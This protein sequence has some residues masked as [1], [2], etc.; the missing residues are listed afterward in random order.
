MPSTPMAYSVWTKLIKLVLN[1]KETSKRSGVRGLFED[2]HDEE[3][4]GRYLLRR[5]WERCE[6]ARK[7]TILVALAQSILTLM[8]IMRKSCVYHKPAGVIVTKVM[9][10]KDV[11]LHAVWFM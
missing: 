4:N 11:H 10:K 6:Y 5:N 2:Y 8:W 9:L 3:E 1:S 7:F